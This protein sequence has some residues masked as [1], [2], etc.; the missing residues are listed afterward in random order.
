V[1]GAEADPGQVDETE[2]DI[3]NGDALNFALGGYGKGLGLVELGLD[4]AYV[5]D[6]A[7]GAR[8]NL[9]TLRDA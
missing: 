5:F 4:E 3:S 9:S 8:E 6:G 1:G 2:G 7:F